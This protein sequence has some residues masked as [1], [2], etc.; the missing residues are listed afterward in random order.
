MKIAYHADFIKSYNRRFLNSPNI[1][2]IFKTKL[3]IFIKDPKNDVLK[4]HQLKGKKHKYRSFSVTG[5]IRVVYYLEKDT[6]TL[7]DIGT[8]NQVY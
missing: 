3:E 4:D 7:F 2:Q 5:D 1:R 6:A 8:H